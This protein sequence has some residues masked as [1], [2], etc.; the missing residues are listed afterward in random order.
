VTT[1]ADDMFTLLLDDFPI[2]AS[3]L[4][5]PGY[6]D[7]MRD[8]TEEGDREIRERAVDILRRAGEDAQEDPVTRAVVVQQ[9]ESLIALIDSRTVEHQVAEGLFGPVNFLF[10]MLP[11]IDAAPRLPKIPEYLRQVATR[12]RGTE[13][14]PLTRHVHT[15][16]E[17]IDTY[18]ASPV[19]AW[20][21]TPGRCA[22]R[23]PSTATCWRTRSCRTAATTTTRASAGCP[24][25]GGTTSCWWSAT[26]PPSTHPSSCTRSG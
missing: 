11:M 12:L 8:W 6:E 22:P 23:S 19:A 17:R 15:A 25:A 3:L 14:S 16:I 24:T 13:R 18:L 4:G 10:T 2:M 5:I 1:I 26:P 9:A 21:R 20:S 7:R